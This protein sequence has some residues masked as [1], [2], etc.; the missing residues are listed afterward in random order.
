MSEKTD[1]LNLS[2]E[3]S[4]YLESFHSPA[5]SCPDHNFPRSRGD[6]CQ[7]HESADASKVARF[8]AGQLFLSNF[9][10]ILAFTNAGGIVTGNLVRDNVRLAR[11]S[12]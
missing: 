10:K 3:S 2:H 7:L 12:R 1:I 11:A 4:Q 9:L 5:G 6:R 8:T